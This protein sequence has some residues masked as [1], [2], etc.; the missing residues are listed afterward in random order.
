[1]RA[2]LML[3]NRFAGVGLGVMLLAAVTA[4]GADHIRVATL[5][6]TE[7]LSVAGFGQPHSVTNN[8][9]VTAQS[10]PSDFGFE[11]MT[12]SPV[13]VAANQSSTPTATTGDGI[14]AP[15]D[16]YASPSGGGRGRTSST[17]FTIQRF[18]SVASPGRTLCLLNGTY[19]GATGM[20]KPPDGLR[21]TS[22]SPITIRAVNDGEVLIDGEFARAPVDFRNNS[23]LIIEGLNL[24]NGR[25]NVVRLADGGYGFGPGTGSNDNILRRIVGWDAD[26]RFNIALAEMAGAD[27]NLFEDSAFFGAARNTWHV[28]RGWDN[29][30]RR[31]WVRLEA[32]LANWSAGPVHAFQPSY[33]PGGAGAGRTVLENVIATW[34]ALSMPQTYHPWNG[35]DNCWS[36]GP[37]GTCNNQQLTDHAMSTQRT[38]PLGEEADAGDIKNNKVLGS[39][40]YLRSG[41]SI[42]TASNAT[43]VFGM[44]RGIGHTLQDVL[45]V[46]SP[47][48]TGATSILAFDFGS[49]SG[50]GACNATTCT[51][52]ANRITA[53]GPRSPLNVIGT[54]GATNCTS[55]QGWTLTNCYAG[56]TVPTDSRNPFTGTAAANLCYRYLN[57]VR[58]D[59]TGGTTVQPLWPWPMDQRIK[60]ALADAGSYA[61]PC[62]KCSGGRRSRVGTADV[63]ADI[64]ALLGPIP[65]ACRT[66]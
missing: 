52:T 56:A 48:Y 32:T 21:G 1:M 18:W 59:G 14:G 41:D 60:A 19:T 5:A 29:I 57:G 24:K 35:W 43:T 47:G 9:V 12:S 11:G 10:T 37:A 8:S 17:P 4:V 13:T 23:W 25:S 6:A 53:I 15:C 62:V 22:T 36:S 2:G 40:F 49:Q 44:R 42:S 55:S 65:A 58:Q 16:Y 38:G 39:L 50:T 33:S 54:A 30:C 51:G 26:A 28:Y 66:Q 64:E 7:E 20:I 27:R 61:G 3:K 63:T 45:A 46:I 34:Y 31:C